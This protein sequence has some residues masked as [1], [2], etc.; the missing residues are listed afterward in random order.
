MTAD[1]IVAQTKSRGPWATAFF[2]L[3]RDK[4]AV[5][6]LVVFL[7]IVIACLSA[8]LYARFSQTEPFKST[9]DAT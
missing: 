6:A 2:R 8:P 9:L 5:T 4:P 3:T 7:L 1:V